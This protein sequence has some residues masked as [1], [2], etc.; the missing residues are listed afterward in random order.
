MENQMDKATQRKWYACEPQR[1]ING[2]YWCNIRFD[3]KD[4]TSKRPLEITGKTKEEVQE[5]SDLIV[6]A[7][8]RDHL[9][10][11]LLTQVQFMYDHYKLAPPHA[12]DIEDLIQQ[13]KA[14]L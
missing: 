14:A 11:Q 12:K 6:K 8:N 1:D 9:F 4:G 10:E 5:K 2:Y 3:E 13:A 7:V